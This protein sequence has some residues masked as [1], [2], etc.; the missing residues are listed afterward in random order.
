[1]RRILHIV[2]K[3]FL[4]LKRDKRMFGI[5]ILGPILQLVLLG[6]AATVDVKNIPIVI[7]DMDNSVKSRQLVER[8][9]SSGYF[10]NAGY[11]NQLKDIDGYF[12]RGDAGVALIIPKNFGRD[13][14]AGRSPELAVI[15]DGSDSN[16]GGIGLNYA[17]MIA[18]NYARGLIVRRAEKYN[19]IRNSKQ[20]PI[21]TAQ[22]RVW[23]NP[24]LK[25]TNFMVPAVLVMVLMVITLILT[26]MAIVK[27]KEIGTI[28]QIVVT[29]ISD[30]EFIIGKM[31]PFALIGFAE[32]FLVLLVS[33]F[34]FHVPMRGNI[35]TLIFFSFL[36]VLVMLGLGLFVSSVSKTQ[37]Q[38]SMTA[39]FFI[40]MPFI[41][42]SGFIFPIA[43]MPVIIQYITY[44]IPVRYF[45]EIVR[46]LFLK[47]DGFREL[48]PQ[49]LALLAMG[50]ISLSLSAYSFRRSIR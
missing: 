38:A 3:E 43:N 22:S 40:M 33:F 16:T 24:E 9:I 49:A 10:T 25:S 44:L 48:Y 17:S 42:L 46:G 50:A 6:Y 47:G 11:T 37:Q 23:Y 45:L 12:E 28:E 14:M 36:F 35:L 32:V 15:A 29:P 13:I 30:F 20:F 7:C 31:I 41:V 19:F 4:Q 27:E 34:V 26:S 39:Q 8:Y 21:V 2:K 1:M 18:M 5:T